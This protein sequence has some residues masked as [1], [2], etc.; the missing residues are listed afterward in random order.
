MTP[1]AN[2]ILIKLNQT[3]TI[4]ETLDTSRLIGLSRNRG[5]RVWDVLVQWVRLQLGFKYLVCSR[6]CTADA[7]DTEHYVPSIFGVRLE[8]LYF[9]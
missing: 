9:L 2:S 3:G 6:R 8:E 1:L 5:G 4:T 7:A